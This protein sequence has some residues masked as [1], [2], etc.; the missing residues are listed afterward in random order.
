MGKKMIGG[1]LHIFGIQINLSDL[2]DPELWFWIVML[3][4][5]LTGLI[6][7]I[8]VAAGV[9]LS[10]KSKKENDHNN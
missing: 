4:I 1:S 9:D 5:G 3:I 6:I 10:G 2:M 8:L 7:I